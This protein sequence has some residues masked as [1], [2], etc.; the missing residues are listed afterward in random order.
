MLAGEVYDCGDEKPLT[1]WHKA[2]DL[3][4]LGRILRTT[5]L[6]YYHLRN[7]ENAKKV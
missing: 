7:K 4:A 3:L 2:K 1:Q 6:F 5:G